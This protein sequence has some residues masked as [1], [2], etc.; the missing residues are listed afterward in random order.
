[1][2]RRNFFLATAAATAAA[3]TPAFA[4]KT[5][6]PKRSLRIAHLTDIHVMPDKDAPEKMARAIQH[7]QS[8]TDKPDLILNGGDCIMDALKRSKSET[9]AQWSEWHGVLKN[10]LELPF[11]SAIGNHDIWGWALPNS[12][13][14]VSYGKQWAMEEL[15]LKQRYYSFEKNNWQFIVL[16][17][18]HFEPSFKS[19]YT[20]KLDEAQ[21]AWLAQTLAE[22]DPKK[23]ICILS[24]IPIISFCPFFD[25]DNEKSGD[26]QVPGPW[27]HIDARRIKDLFAQHPNVKLALSGHIHLR[28]QVRYLG[29]DYLCNGAVSGGWWD[30]PYQEF[31]SAYVLVD[32]YE[33]GTS[34]SQYVPYLES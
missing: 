29:I 15:A 21:F 34:Q 6:Q 5:S 3:A 24:H 7:A 17:S 32:L 2:N 14:N 31:P 26:W 10:E 27:M 11:Y 25:G 8:Q 9:K 23:P 22:S 19:G 4:K 16:D 28:D 1:M 33:D 20:A 12:K 13:K 18:S 30:G